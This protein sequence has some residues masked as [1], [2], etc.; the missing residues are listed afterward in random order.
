M[1][2]CMHDSVNVGSGDALPALVKSAVLKTIMR[3]HIVVVYHVHVIG[4]DA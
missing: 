4:F 2:A 1:C 3:P